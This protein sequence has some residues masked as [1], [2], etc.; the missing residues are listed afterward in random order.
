MTDEIAAA[1]FRDHPWPDL[2]RRI[3]SDVL[4]VPAV[5]I[6]DP[7]ILIVLMEAN[8]STRLAALL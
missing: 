7:V 4:G 2:P 6:G 8:D 5:E 3:V 1:R